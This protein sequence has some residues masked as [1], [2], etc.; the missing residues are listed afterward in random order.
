M[1]LSTTLTD[2]AK[3]LGRPS[4][5]V[6]VVSITLHPS[7]LDRISKSSWSPLLFKI[8]I[9]FKAITI[10]IPSSISWVVKNRL[11]LKFAPSTMLIITS[12]FSSN[13]YSLVIASSPVY[14]EIE[15]VPGRSTI[16]IS[17]L[18]VLYFLFKFASFTETVTPGQLPTDSVLPVIALYIVVLPELGLPASAILTRLP[19]LEINNHYQ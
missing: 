11:L 16:L 17:V 7:S 19:S 1:L 2:S 9:L 12:V 4:S 6:A 10:G 18:Y 5:T 8:S 3:R 14:G 13:M 15:Y